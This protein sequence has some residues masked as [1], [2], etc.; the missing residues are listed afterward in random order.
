MHEV[1]EPFRPLGLLAAVGSRLVV[2]PFG[3]PA[4]VRLLPSWADAL[5]GTIVP[6]ILLMRAASATGEEGRARR[7][8]AAVALVL[9][10]AVAYRARVD[11]WNVTDMENGDRYFFLP[12]VLLAWLVIWECQ[13]A[14][15]AVAWTARAACGWAL[16]LHAPHFVLP[17]PPDYQW[18]KHCDPIRRGTPANI[19]TLPEGW[20]IEYPGRA[21]KG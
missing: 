12:R 9:T 21:A 3:G 14:S 19:Y 7:M 10:L 11:T 5:L 8:I 17:A 20:W 16:V 1:P 4:A 2:W 15:V 18:A 6:A 13:A